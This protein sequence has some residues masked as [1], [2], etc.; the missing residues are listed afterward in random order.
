M[1]IN[2]IVF[3]PPKKDIYVSSSITF[4]T[5]SALLAADS[6]NWNKQQKK[7]KLNR[8]LW[9]DKHDSWILPSRSLFQYLHQYRC[10]V[11][12]PHIVA[13]HPEVAN[14]GHSNMLRCKEQQGFC[15]SLTA[16]HADYNFCTGTTKWKWPLI[17]QGVLEHIWIYKASLHPWFPAQAFHKEWASFPQPCPAWCLL[18]SIH[19]QIRCIP[20]FPLTLLWTTRTTNHNIHR[21]REKR[22][23]VNAAW[24]VLLMQNTWSINYSNIRV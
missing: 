24:R 11:N 22:S 1:L 6:L 2:F 9:H 18:F 16:K 23:R 12:T 14:P 21:G 13:A 15:F 20:S 8:G 17:F 7:M 10:K 4:S 19:S 5:R 3:I